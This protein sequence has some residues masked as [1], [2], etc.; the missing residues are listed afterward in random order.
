MPEVTD[1]EDKA[2]NSVILIYGKE[3]NLILSG[4]IYF[5]YLLNCY[6]T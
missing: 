5:L 1:R 2:L 6:A 4:A 3:K